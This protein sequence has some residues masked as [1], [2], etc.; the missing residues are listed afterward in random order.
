MFQYSPHEYEIALKVKI[1]DEETTEKG[2]LFSEA[3]FI[4]A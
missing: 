2:M 3:T 1:G 4:S